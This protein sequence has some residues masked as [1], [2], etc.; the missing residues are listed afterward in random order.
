MSDVY[1]DAL[2]I[3]KPDPY[4]HVDRGSH[5]EQT[6]KVMVRFEKVCEAEHPDLVLVVGDINSTL[7][8]SVVTKKQNIKLAR[9]EAGL[10]SRDLAM[11]E[12]INRMVSDAISDYLIVTEKSGVDNLLAEGKPKRAIFFI[13]HVMIDILF[14]QVA[15]PESAAKAPLIFPIHP[16][17]QGNLER[18]GIALPDSIV[19]IRPQ[20]CMAFL[21]LFNDVLACAG[22]QRRHSG[23]DH[24]T[25][26]SMTHIAGDH[27]AAH[28]GGR[29]HEHYCRKRSCPN[30]GWGA[31]D[32]RRQ[33][34]VGQSTGIM[35]R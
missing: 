22:R 20:A 5:A 24:R 29:R 1:V 13:G 6:A 2:E 34:K 32:T 21:D 23:G 28:H 19:P 3:P 4:L 18:C 27:R 9:I 33:W 35:G 26:H 10:R 11:P 15:K 16:R 25:G 30:P 12:K 17:T 14:H 7:A 8:C 31:E